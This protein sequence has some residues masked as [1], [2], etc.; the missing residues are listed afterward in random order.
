MQLAISDGAAK[1]FSEAVYRSLARGSSLEAAVSDGRLALYQAQPGSWEWITPALFAVLSDAAVF[2]P[3]CSA[4]EDRTARYEEAVVQA[5]QLL[6]AKSYSR[7]QRVIAAC[8]EQGADLADLHYYHALALLG[9]RRPRYLKLEE[10]RAVEAS[11]RRVLDLEDR[12]AH[13][14]CFL[15]FLCRDFYLENHLLPPPPTFDD[16]VS[17]AVAAPLDQPRMDELVRFL[18]WASP[19]VDLVIERQRSDQR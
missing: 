1:G 5:G 4:A 15:A 7:A 16:L 12:A 11:A 18:P 3:L 14:L 9:G 13:Q 19:V 6:S 8:L 17:R 10:I 2:R